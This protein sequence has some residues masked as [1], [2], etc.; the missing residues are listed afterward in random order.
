MDRQRVKEGYTYRKRMRDF[1]YISFIL[2]DFKQLKLDAF[3][4]I[5][6]YIIFIQYILWHLISRYTVGVWF[7]VFSRDVLKTR[8]LVHFRCWVSLST[9]AGCVIWFC[10]AWILLMAVIELRLLAIR[11]LTTHASSSRSS[12]IEELGFRIAYFPARVVGL[13]YRTKG[14]NPEGAVLI[15]TFLRAGCVVRAM[16]LKKHISSSGIHHALLRPAL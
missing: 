15:I 14:A 4:W 8:W 6:K 3:N 2:W 5:N 10:S 16:H 13:H 9:D 12:V 1:K 11:C 7:A